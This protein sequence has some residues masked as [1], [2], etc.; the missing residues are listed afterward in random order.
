MLVLNTVNFFRDII[1]VAWSLASPNICPAR[2]MFGID[3]FL[4]ESFEPK[5]LEV[6]WAPDCDKAVKLNP[7]F[8]SDILAGLYL[9]ETTNIVPL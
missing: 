1:Y 2:S 4:S 3:I 5:I 7:S 6:Q 8:W 9:D